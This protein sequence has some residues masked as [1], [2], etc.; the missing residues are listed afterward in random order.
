MPVPRDSVPKAEEAFSWG[1]FGLGSR[2]RCL[3]AKE[4]AEREVKRACDQQ[5][6]SEERSPS[7]SIHQLPSEA[8]DEAFVP[9]E[10]AVL[11]HVGAAAPRGHRGKARA[12]SSGPRAALTVPLLQVPPRLL[13][14]PCGAASLPAGCRR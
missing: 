11:G 6:D 5:G 13:A 10:F 4:E 8:D 1:Q 14:V 7:T 3:S 9:G 12:S 2:K